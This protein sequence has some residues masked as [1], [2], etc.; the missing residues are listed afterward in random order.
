MRRSAQGSGGVCHA[1]R[2]RTIDWSR[3][4]TSHALLVAATSYLTLTVLF[5][6]VGKAGGGAVS[7]K[8]PSPARGRAGLRSHWRTYPSSRSGPSG[9]HIS[10][11]TSSANRIA[12]NHIAARAQHAEPGRAANVSCSPGFRFCHPT[13]R[14]TCSCPS[15]VSLRSRWRKRSGAAAELRFQRVAQCVPQEVERQHPRDRDAGPA[16]IHHIMFVR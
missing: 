13:L 4:R 5:R 9:Y 10:G 7:K 2:A 11:T 8:S 6:R 15:L 14:R 1:D 16:L 3:H 12:P